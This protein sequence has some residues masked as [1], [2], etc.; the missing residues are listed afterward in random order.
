MTGHSRVAFHENEEC[1]EIHFL[2]PG[3]EAKNIVVA[4]TRNEVGIDAHNLGAASANDSW[5]AAWEEF[6]ESDAYRRVEFPQ[7]VDIDS[8]TAE[9]K[10]G[11]LLVRVD[12]QKALSDTEI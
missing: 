7:P 5:P 11:V 9:V 3:F 1:F 10:N 4:I 12:K 2:V 8:A 6:S